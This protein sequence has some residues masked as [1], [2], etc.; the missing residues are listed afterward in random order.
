MSQLLGGI[1][2]F[3]CPEGTNATCRVRAWTLPLPPAHYIRMISGT[4]EFIAATLAT[5]F[6]WHRYQGTSGA[7]RPFPTLLV[8]GLVIGY[9]VLAVALFEVFQPD[10]QA[11]RS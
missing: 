6:A 11:L 9:P 1:F 5:Y 10:R 8:L 4:L 7:L 3:A 2:S